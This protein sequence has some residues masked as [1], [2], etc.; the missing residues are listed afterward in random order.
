MF[1]VC[2]WDATSFEATLV[3]ENCLMVE[4]RA[5]NLVLEHKAPLKGRRVLNRIAIE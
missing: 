3:Q 1:G 5:N 2:S 4:G